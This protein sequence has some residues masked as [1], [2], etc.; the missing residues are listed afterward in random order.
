MSRVVN[1]SAGC[2][3][4]GQTDAD[5]WQQLHRQCGD[6]DTPIREALGYL[7][8]WNWTGYPHVD[9]VLMGREGNMELCAYY[10]NEA[11]G[12]AGYVIGAVWHGTHFGFHS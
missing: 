9:I 6:T 1:I 2:L 10:R 5:K 3:D 4:A 12:P 8:L 7:S 11:G